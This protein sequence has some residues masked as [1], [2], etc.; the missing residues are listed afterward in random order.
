MAHFFGARVSSVKDWLTE[1]DGE[2]TPVRCG[3]RKGLLALSKDLKDLKTPPPDAEAGWPLQ[4]LPLWESMLM[5][6]ADKSWTVPRETDR[7]RVWRKAAYVCPVV[8]ARGRV[9]ATW[10]HSQK[11]RRLA[12]EIQ[13]LS[14]WRKSRHIAGVHTE[15]KAIADHLELDGA[16]V[17]IL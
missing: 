1:L 12:V 9:V 4:M 16:D 8:L 15:A 17:T 2:L 5:G 14:A 13:P 11:K 10:S 6:H 7:T 3:T